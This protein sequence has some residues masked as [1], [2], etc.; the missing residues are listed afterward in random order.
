[1]A[2][3]PTTAKSARTRTSS[4]TTNSPSLA[5]LNA[6]I[7]ELQRQAEELRRAEI[8]E[9]VGK[10]KVAIVEYGLTAA[11]LGLAAKGTRRGGKSGSAASSNV[12]YTDG[13]NTWT[14]RGRRPQWFLDALASG[15]S[16]AD[17]RA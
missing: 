10:I 8:A 7:A 9:V 17:L 1:M 5:A 11:D 3:T 4:A 15:S 14:G 16:E 6:Q 12:K 13:K 2:R